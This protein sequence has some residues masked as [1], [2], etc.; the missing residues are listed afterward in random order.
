[1]TIAILRI[2][3]QLPMLPITAAEIAREIKKDINLSK[4]K[5]KR[6]RTRLLLQEN[7]QG[8]FKIYMGSILKGITVVICTI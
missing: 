8:Y 2:V 6:G 4:I 7:D 1:M 3:E 5:L